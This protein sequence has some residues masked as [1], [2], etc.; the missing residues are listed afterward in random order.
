MN[1]YVGVP[2]F[3]KYE[4]KSQ[5]DRRRK[6]QKEINQKEKAAKLN[7]SKQ[8]KVRP[9]NISSMLKKFLLV[10]NNNKSLFRNEKNGQIQLK[11]NDLGKS[12]TRAD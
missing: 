11:T 1:I 3:T 2:D 4:E 8:M 6:E 12:M 9:E 10:N 7:K 5:N